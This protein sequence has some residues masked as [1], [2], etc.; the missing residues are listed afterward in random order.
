MVPCRFSYEFA[1]RVSTLL[2]KTRPVAEASDLTTTHAVVMAMP[3]LVVPLERLVLGGRQTMREDAAESDLAAALRGQLD[4][5]FDQTPF[6][7]PSTAD[8]WRI[9]V[10]PD[11]V[12][13]Q[14]ER[15]LDADGRHPC[16]PGA[17][18]QAPASRFG[19]IL[20]TLRHGLSHGN[21]VYL[22]EQGHERPN[23]PV[24]QLAFISRTKG[25][26]GRP[27]DGRHQIVIV[28]E[29]EFLAFLLRW[30]EWLRQWTLPS[31]LREAA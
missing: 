31:S 2:S 1:Q 5:R 21:V 20:L 13:D 7:E 27:W 29:V 28:R 22:D 24:T 8:A 9:L 11:N 3:L 23:R 10:V 18:S 26:H 6:F 4:L 25:E 12:V 15:W 19:V 30:A 17:V 16:A 14:P